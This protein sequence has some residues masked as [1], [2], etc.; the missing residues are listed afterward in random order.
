MPDL[1][2]IRSYARKHRNGIL[3]T[4]FIS[5][6][7][8]LAS[9]YAKEQLL[10]NQKRAAAERD[11]KL[12]FKK[13][14]QQNQNDCVFTV[15]SLLPTLGDQI[16]NEMNVEVYWTRLQESRKLE[17]Q[18]QQQQQQRDHSN[19]GNDVL[20]MT[21]EQ[22]AI[23]SRILEKEQKYQLW[24][25]IKVQSFSRSLTTLYSVTMLTLLTYLQL[26]LLG[27]FAYVWTA[28]MA[29]KR[30]P[31]MQFHHEQQQAQ[32]HTDEVGPID[33]QTEDI[34]LSTSWW[35][36]HRGWRIYAKQVETAVHDVISSL[37]LKRIVTCHDAQIVVGK[38]RKQIENLEDSS[39]TRLSSYVFPNDNEAVREMLFEMGYANAPPDALAKLK[40]L[41]DA[42]KS[43]MNSPEFNRL[44]V[45]CLD[46]VFQIFHQHAF[47][48]GHDEDPAAKRVTLANLLPAV[49]RQAHRI[50]AGSEYL[51]ELAYCNEVK[52]FSALINKQ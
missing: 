51:N 26:D 44:Y 38:L 39:K 2:S 30:E 40:R 46:R 8:Y 6:C 25:E 50:I 16:L 24:E 20:T 28:S 1:Q 29:N 4:I 49:S 9:R 32:C 43:Y 48:G 27:R 21:A 14:F 13:R 10:E 34:Y 31:V 3:A 17:K 35:L 41:M 45:A 42:T 18:L 37:P 22:Q 7:G 36:L 33:P 52:E 23:E 15:L 5:V 47:G 11:T 12:N 19:N